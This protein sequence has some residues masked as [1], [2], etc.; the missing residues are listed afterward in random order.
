MVSITL[1]PETVHTRPDNT[2]F[3][4]ILCPFCS[5][6]QRFDI[7]PN[8]VTIAAVIHKCQGKKIFFMNGYAFD[9]VEQF[10]AAEKVSRAVS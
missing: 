5:E 1:A 10:N 9:G 6:K 2:A 7:P 3:R 4:D 8:G